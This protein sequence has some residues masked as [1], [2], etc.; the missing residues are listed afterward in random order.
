AEEPVERRRA[1]P[2]RRRNLED[3]RG[4]QVVRAPFQRISELVR[5]ISE[6]VVN[7]SLFDEHY[8]S[9]IRQVEAVKLSTQRLRRVALELETDYGGRARAGNSAPPP[10]GAHSH[11]FD[12][13]EFDRYT[14]F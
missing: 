14:D 12:E 11:G 5:L 6:L 4:G 8:A 2:D 7:R 3:R 10:A 9:L 13:L 1:G